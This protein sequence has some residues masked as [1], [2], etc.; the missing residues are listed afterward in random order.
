M[1][2]RKAAHAMRAPDDRYPR[3]NV[4]LVE[5]HGSEVAR[6]PHTPVGSG[7]PWKVTCVHPNC[8]AEFHELGH[9]RGPIVTARGHMAAGS[10]V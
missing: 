3:S 2:F 8:L 1:A 7:I 5:K 9:R 4:D 6:H 10:C